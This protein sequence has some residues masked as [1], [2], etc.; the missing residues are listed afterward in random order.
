MHVTKQHKVILLK[1]LIHLISLICLLWQYYLA[2][3]DFSIVDPVMALTHFTGIGALN[4]LLLTLAVSPIVQHFKLHYLMSIR[5]LLGLYCFVYALLHVANFI[6]FDLQ[7][8]WLLFVNELLKR[9]YLTIGLLAFVL[10]TLLA[11]TSLN[12]LKRKMGRHWQNLHNF[13]YLAII[14]VVVHFYWSVKSSLIE[15]I[16]YILISVFLLTLRK[17]RIQ[18]W[19]N[20]KINTL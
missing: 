16:I 13:I 2:I 18:R 6:A 19:L 12:S 1:S 9:P 11:L 5:R 15:P 20:I 4:L 7:F 10:L 17:K 14:L 8:N 3:T